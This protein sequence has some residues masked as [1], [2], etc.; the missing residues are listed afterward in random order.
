MIKELI[1]ARDFS[2]W[3]KNT[4][5]KSGLA[6]LMNPNFHSLVLFRVESFLFKK[7]LTLLAKFLWFFNRCFYSIDIDFRA[8]IGEH[9]MIIHGLGIVIGK[10][11]KIGDDCKIYQ[12]TTIGGNGKSRKLNSQIISMP[13]I[14]NNCTIYSNSIILGPI[15]LEEN[16][17]VGAGT[18]DSKD[19]ESNLVIRNHVELIKKI[20]V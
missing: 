10:S 17:V 1:I 5:S 19:V 4:P 7:K 6:V 18:V 3:K 13:I 12:N 15:I 9:F 11:V 8:S 20:N 16:I 14:K 2:Y